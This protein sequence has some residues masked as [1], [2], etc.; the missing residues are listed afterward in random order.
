M[1]R[2]ARY[3]ATLTPA[4]T[5]GSSQQKFFLPL[6]DYPRRCRPVT[7]RAM[8]PAP[9]QPTALP[10]ATVAVSSSRWKEIRTS[11]TRRYRLLPS[12]NGLSA[13]SRTQCIFS[14][15]HPAHRAERASSSSLRHG[16]AYLKTVLRSAILPRGF[17]AASDKPQRLQERQARRYR[18][19]ES[20]NAKAHCAVDLT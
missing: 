17:V 16:N 19:V 2:A 18:I 13:S 1:R 6:A 7:A 8:R 12:I 20:I 9:T 15:S 10:E 4:R 5:L 11:M 3:A 14:D